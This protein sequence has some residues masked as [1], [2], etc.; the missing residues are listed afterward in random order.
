MSKKRTIAIVEQEIKDLVT[1]YNDANMEENLSSMR[2]INGKLDETEKEYAKL[3]MLT[4]FDELSKTEQPMYEAIKR[5]SYGVI[6]HRDNVDKETNIATRE[7]VY[8]DKQID[9]VK[10]E[11]YCKEK[12]INI[13]PSNDWRYAIQKFNQLLCLR[14]AKELGVKSNPIKE[15]FYMNKIAKSIEMGE[16]PTSNTA[17][18]K[19]LQFIID[20]MLYT[21]GE[22]GNIYKASSKDVAYLNMLYT[23]KGKTILSIATAKHGFLNALV[24]D[25]LHKAVCKKDYSIE[26]KLEKNN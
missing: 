26:C 18:L 5:Y 11:D 25:V 16:T 17:M 4:I 24:M 19:Q 20:K 8:K 14:A 2:E 9:L 15:S 7:V 22:H 1:A 12:K 3:S 6:K 23:K 13:A 10:F 21:E